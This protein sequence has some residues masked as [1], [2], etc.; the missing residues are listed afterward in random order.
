MKT[1]QMILSVILFLL[2]GCTAVTNTENT[3]MPEEPEE[4]PVSETPETEPTPTDDD[5]KQVSEPVTVDLG[6]VTPEPIHGTPVVQPAPGNPGVKDP[7]LLAVA[8]LSG[9]L[10]MSEDEIEVVSLQEVTWRDGSL[11]CPQAN[12]DYIQ[13]LTPGQQLILRANGQ[14]YHY[15]SGKNSVFK[16]CGNPLPP[17]ENPGVINP[18]HGSPPGQDD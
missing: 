15:H 3:P 11:G 8:D 1:T 14:D 18:S 5:D 12:V 10:N 13:V 6:S 4:A 2:V 9:R 17:I 7:V 16:F